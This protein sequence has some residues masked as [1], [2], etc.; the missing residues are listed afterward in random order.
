MTGL[1]L[2]EERSMSEERRTESAGSCSEAQREIAE[3]ARRMIMDNLEKHLKIEELAHELHVSQTQIK[4][5]FRN[6]YGMPIYSYSRRKRMEEAARLLPGFWR[7]RTKPYLRLPARPGTRTGANSPRL[8]G[9][10]S[11]RLPANTGAGYF[12]RKQIRKPDSDR[13]REEGL[14]DASSFFLQG[15]G[16]PAIRGRQF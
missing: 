10:R 1:I 14:D 5:C 16:P 6:Y 11:E 3:K 7:R 12:G 2:K 13:P 8:S 15:S 9:M 4:V